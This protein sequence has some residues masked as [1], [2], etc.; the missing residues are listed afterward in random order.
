MK[1]GGCWRG[2]KGRPWALA[3]GL[4]LG[5]RSGGEQEKNHTL[6]WPFTQITCSSGAS[7]GQ[8]PLLEFRDNIVLVPKKA[9]PDP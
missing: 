6:R 4:D 1:G 2:G 5:L 9:R 8:T 3:S 7:C